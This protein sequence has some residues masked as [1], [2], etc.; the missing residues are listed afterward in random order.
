MLL[1]HILC[2]QLYNY[3]ECI[4]LIIFFI[5]DNKV[6]FYCL[7]ARLTKSSHDEVVLQS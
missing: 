5:F 4:Q 6:F 7:M 1:I 3:I 2:K